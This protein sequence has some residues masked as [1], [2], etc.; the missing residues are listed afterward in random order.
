MSN[1][2]TQV[3]QRVDRLERRVGEL[4]RLLEEQDDNH[5]AAEKAGLDTRDA[6]VVATLEHGETYTRPDIARRYIHETEIRGDRHATDRAEQL[7]DRDFFQ[8][9]N[10]GHTYRG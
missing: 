4:E 3:R 7:L 6:A 1:D 5:S 10:S 8:P 2:L 9:A